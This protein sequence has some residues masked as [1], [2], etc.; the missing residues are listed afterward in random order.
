[1]DPLTTLEQKL[2]LV[3]DRV[4]GVAQG[5]DNGFYLWGEGGTS[6]SFTVEQTLDAISRRYVLTNTRITPKGLFELLRDFPDS[7]HVLEDV[8]T[9]LKEKTAAN[10]LR[11][12][13]WGQVNA[14]GVV[15][16]PVQWAISG[17]RQ[18]FLF[19]GGLIFTVNC[20]LDNL[21]EL[22]ALKTRIPVVQFSP[23]NEEIAALMHQI[24]SAGYQYGPHTLGPAACLEVMAVIIE[25][26]TRIQR[27]LDLR[28]LINGFHDRLQWQNGFAE[29]H[30]I[31]LLDSRIK[32]RVT[33]PT[34]PMGRQA[35]S[36][37]EQELLGRIVDLPASERLRAWIEATGKSRATLY[38]QISLYRRETGTN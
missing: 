14:H 30:W 32:E 7:I 35:Q 10:I 2:Q 27:N 3:R 13:L 26:S 37:E 15:E 21:P 11:S 19:T 16:R 8:E 1:M 9:L 28:L 38:R 12:A 18:E 33:E 24:A 29:T 36:A 20:P 25:R 34:E 31:D 4:V 22:R 6:K 5:Y 17:D 23:T